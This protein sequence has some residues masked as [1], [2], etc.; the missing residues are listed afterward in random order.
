[1]LYSGLIFLSFDFINI[2]YLINVVLWVVVFITFP[3]RTPGNLEILQGKQKFC[4]V[5][6]LCFQSIS[7][8][9]F[10][11]PFS[12]TQS[13]VF[14]FAPPPPL[15]L[16]IT[17]CLGG[18]RLPRQGTQNFAPPYIGSDS[19]V[20]LTLLLTSLFL[21]STSIGCISILFISSDRSSYSDSVLLLVHAAATFSDFEHFCQHI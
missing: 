11:D 8:S 12:P 21:T 16:K 17:L 7:N 4:F 10:K 1:M 2:C 3:T 9:F 20:C 13:L 18:G 5:F 6:F 19:H 15:F 14:C